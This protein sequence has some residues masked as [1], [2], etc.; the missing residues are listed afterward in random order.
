V[1]ETGT[2]TDFTANYGMDK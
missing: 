1:C 2:V